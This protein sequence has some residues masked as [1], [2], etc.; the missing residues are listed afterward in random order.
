MPSKIS[1]KAGAFLA[2]IC[3]SPMVAFGKLMPFLKFRTP[4]EIRVGPE[5]AKY[6][7][8]DVFTVTSILLVLETWGFDYIGVG[9]P[10]EVT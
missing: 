1:R 8:F 3:R 10:H 4:W 9:P 6:P 5:G 7:H 2:K